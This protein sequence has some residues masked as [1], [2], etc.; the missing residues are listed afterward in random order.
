MLALFSTASGYEIFIYRPYKDK[1]PLFREKKLFI[2]GEFFGQLQIPSTFPSFNDYSGSEDRWNY[3]FRNLIFLTDSTYLTAQLVTHDDGQKRTK[4]DWHFS[5]RQ[6]F[7][8]N[9]VLIVGHDSNHDSDYKSPYFVN[10]NYIGLGL[11][12]EQGSFYLEPFTWFF[13]HTNQ[14]GHLDQSGNKLR[15][16]YGLRIGGWLS[17]RT[18]FHLQVIAQTEKLFSLGQAFLADLIIRVKMLE[19]MEL[20]L[21]A[22]L[23]KDIGESRLG[24]HKKFYKFIWGIAIPF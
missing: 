12:F 1:K 5:F 20:S 14:R 3:G 17:G 23:Y 4:F 21:G 6:L 16:E 19:W 2:R 10:R 24:N 8:Q 18:S 22:S 11:P 9:L 15:Q 13:H 7:T